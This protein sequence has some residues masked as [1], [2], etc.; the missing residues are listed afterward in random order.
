MK[1]RSFSI[2]LEEIVLTSFI[3]VVFMLPSMPALTVANFMERNYTDRPASHSANMLEQM[4]FPGKDFRQR[5]SITS[6]WRCS[7]WT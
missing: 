7:D 2:L 6:T 1:H 4:S 5:S 3:I